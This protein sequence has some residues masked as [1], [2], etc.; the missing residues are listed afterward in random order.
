M[1]E[2]NPLLNSPFFK[3]AMRLKG[4]GRDLLAEMRSGEFR[5]GGAGAEPS[6]AA[7]GQPTIVDPNRPQPEDTTDY[8][9]MGWGEVASKALEAAPKS[10]VKTIGQFGEAITH[11]TETLGTLGQVGTG[12]LSKGAGF[13][14]PQDQAKKAQDEALVNAIGKHYADVYGDLFSG[15]AGLKR[16]L[17]TDPFSVGMDVATLAPGVGLAGKLAG[18]EKAGKLAQTALSALDPVQAATMT[19][20]GVFGVGKGISKNLLSRTSG[21]DVPALDIIENAAKT[22]DPAG[23]RV[24]KQY[25]GGKGSPEDI[26]ETAIKALDQLKEG[27]SN[28]YLSTH[29]NLITDPLNT[30]MVDNAFQEII[31]D[32]GTNPGVLNPEGVQMLVNMHAK[33]RALPNT[34][35]VA[36]DDL[37]KSLSAD[38]SDYARTTRGATMQGSFNKVLDAIKDTIIAKDKTY[39]EMLDNW[40]KW[41]N[42]LKEF[43]G[44]FGLKKNATT[45]S[46]LTKLLKSLKS[47]DRQSLLNELAK[48]EAGKYLPHMIAGTAVS[49]WLPDWAHT[50]QDALL[51]GVGASQLGFGVPHAIGT[52]AAA[53]PKV[54]GAG[55]YGLGKAE[56]LAGLASPLVTSPGTNVLSQIGGMMEPAQ[57]ASGSYFSGGR[58]ARQSGGRVKSPGSAADKLIAAA[59]KAKNRHSDDTSPLLDVPDEAIT[60]ALAIANEKI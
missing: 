37:R 27:A 29:Q 19:G 22:G 42:K 53:S 6:M 47:G 56:K 4:E 35:A 3:E 51:Y 26:P 43:Q 23:Q 17:S 40:S 12:L 34:T 30:S 38:L 54:V 52:L 57:T 11:P 60:K 28:S 9:K 58:V 49:E 5:P 59:E 46:Q 50:V 33:Y 45:A 44:T 18:V 21:V 10:F 1:A 8:G 41:R 32:L 36:L 16:E 24:L 14:G 13:F 20:K 7:P 2:E 55:V 31:K 15:G 25:M 39:G 48:T